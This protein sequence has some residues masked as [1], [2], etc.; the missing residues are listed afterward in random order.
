MGAELALSIVNERRLGEF[1]A[2][3]HASKAIMAA[4]WTV[5]GGLA[6][7]ATRRPMLAHVASVAYLAAGL[8]FRYGWVRAGRA[9]A[10]DD[11]AVARS[12]RPSPDGASPGS[13]AS[14][15]P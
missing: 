8:M 1:A 2:P 10:A 6:L 7:Q 14:S 15:R 13:S 4:K 12:N 11:M 9:S 5:R 3:L